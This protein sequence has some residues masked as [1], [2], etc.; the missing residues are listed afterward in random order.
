MVKLAEQ[1]YGLLMATESSTTNWISIIYRKV[2][3]YRP[4]L[5]VGQFQSFHGAPGQDSVNKRSWQDT[6]Q[7]RPLAGIRGDGSQRWP[8]V[9]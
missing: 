7:H 5:D 8:R 3:S 2:H 9:S 4:M 6:G 1:I